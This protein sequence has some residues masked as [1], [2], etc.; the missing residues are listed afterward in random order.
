MKK[1]HAAKRTCLRS[2]ILLAAALAGV[3]SLLPT[4]AFGQLSFLNAWGSSGTGNGEFKDPTGVAVAPDGTVYVT[5]ESNDRVET[6]SST[7]TFESTFG[8]DGTGNG[9]FVNPAG[10]AV[11]SNDMVYV[12]DEDNNRVETFN[13]NGTFQSAFGTSGS[14]NGQFADPLGVAVGPSGTVYVLD[15]LNERVETFSS[16]GTFQ[17]TFG[18]YGTG[19]GQFDFPQGIAVGP[20]GTVYVTDAASVETFNSAGSYGSTF[21]SAGSGNGQ[22]ND[23]YGV[24][25]GPTGTVYVADDDNYRVEAFSSTGTF[26]SALGSSGSGNGEFEYPTGVAVAPNG[27]VYVTDDDNNRVERLFDPGSWVSGTNTFTDPT[28]GPTSVEAG[29]FGGNIGLLGYDFTLTSAMGLVVGNIL[30]VGP[31][32]IL[33]QSGATASAAQLSIGGNNSIADAVFNYQSGAHEFSSIT[34]GNYGTLSG[35]PFTVNAAET[36]SVAGGTVSSDILTIATNSSATQSSGTLSSPILNVQG[37]YNYAGGDFAPATVNVQSGGELQFNAYNDITTNLQV[38]S[39]GEFSISALCKL[40]GADL[41][42]NGGLV[43]GSGGG[44]IQNFSGSITGA[45]TISCPVTNQSLIEPVGGIL[46]FTGAVTNYGTILVPAGA[47]ALFSNL[48][49]TDIDLSGGTVDTA[50]TTLANS[51][52]ISGYGILRTGGLTN[53]G[54]ISLAGNSSVYG[55]VTNSTGGLIQL[56]GS[57]P[58]VFF[59]AVTNNGTFFIDAGATASIYAAYN[60][61]GS[62]VDNGSLYLLSNSSTGPISGTGVLT[63]GQTTTAAAVLQLTA[64]GGVST[65]GA[66]LINAGSKLDL[67]NNK[68]FI[69]YGSGPDP[70]ASIAAWIENGY[71]NLPGPQII[72][73]AIATADAASGLLYGIGYAD[74]ADPGDP[75]NL[76]AD[77]IEIMFTLLGDANLDGTVNTEDFTLFSHNLG[78]SGMMW[79]DGDFNY[80]GTVNA[81]DFTLFSRNLGQSASLAAQAGFLDSAN[82]ISPANVPEPMSAG[83]MVIAGLGIFRRRRRS[84]H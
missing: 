10:I 21:G 77:T 60:G 12:A 72:S 36:L 5:D 62:L 64:N 29:G 1:R 34:V 40:A 75:A 20:T 45:G 24:A 18:S 26:Q 83:L 4:R 42:V 51:E 48:T 52:N 80:D 81:E 58:N 27:M 32:G 54:T 71:Y 53:T 33:M 61:S 67:T 73:S 46:D 59:G 17:S 47:E 31:N 68:M 22:L 50:G 13:S 65:I 7:G 76:P 78:Q 35:N 44:Y 2:G 63:I 11:G 74:S 16:T 8:S 82:G 19:N 37:F 66:L 23:P 3:E 28:V 39:G 38:S 56:S 57:G 25:V 14:G 84:L 55:S 70:I 15:Q 43:A 49:G 6:F 69:N 41:Q 9:Q 79:D 30:S